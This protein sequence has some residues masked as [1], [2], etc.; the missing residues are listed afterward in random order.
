MKKR[1]L[2]L[3]PLLLISSSLSGC[4]NKGNLVKL[5]Y[6]QMISDETTEIDY[7]SLKEKMLN[8]ETFILA[9]YNST[10]A[11]WSEFKQV[12]KEYISSNH[13]IIYSININK[14]NLGS[15]NEVD[16]F[17]LSLIKSTVTLHIIENGLIR[18][19]VA[20]P[21]TRITK[22]L[23]A[24]SSYLNGVTT[25]PNMYYVS[26]DQVNNLYKSEET[27]L[28]YFARSNCSDCQYIDNTLL[29]N[30]NFKSNNKMY[31]LDCESIGIREYDDSGALT[32]ESQEKWNEFKINYGLAS[33][34]NMTYGYDSG[35]VPSFFLIKGNSNSDMP[36]FLSGAVYFNDE[37]GKDENG[38][39]VKNSYYTEERKTNLAYLKDVPSSVLKGLRLSED[40][41][42]QYGDY[43]YWL[44]EKAAVY[45]DVLMTKFIDYA[46]EKV[47]HKAF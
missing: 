33:E 14:F 41:V 44:Q 26:L 23:N 10:C 13:V 34:K 21:T 24:F 12:A 31:I 45:H 36:T 6:G 8:K 39:Y 3:L 7:Q 32:K 19:E 15:L 28:L 18:N 1:A 2:F 43:I 42:G 40:S 30:Y 38:Y 9:V 16:T 17:N 22:N 20:D 46:L 27:S 4:N 5:T 25:M 11:C 37:I 29:K 35:Y 47:T